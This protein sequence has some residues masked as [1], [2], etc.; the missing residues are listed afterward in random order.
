MS[1]KHVLLCFQVLRHVIQSL[2]GKDFL[3][4]YIYLCLFLPASMLKERENVISYMIKM[5]LLKKL[6]KNNNF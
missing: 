2:R 4:I 3:V 5:Q 6:T 1:L